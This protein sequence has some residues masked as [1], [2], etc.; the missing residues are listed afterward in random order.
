MLCWGGMFCCEVSQWTCS[1]KQRS[2]VQLPFKLRLPWEKKT[3]G[4]ATFSQQK[5]TVL[6][7]QAAFCTLTAGEVKVTGFS[8]GKVRKRELLCE[9]VQMFE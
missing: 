3:P 8:G 2:L 1:Q 6:E 4:H 5:C 7:L 9:Y